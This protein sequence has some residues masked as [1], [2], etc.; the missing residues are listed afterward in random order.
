MS[1]SIETKRRLNDGLMGL[2]PSAI[3]EFFDL[4]THCDDIVSLGVGEPDFVTPWATREHAI[5]TLERGATTYTSNKGLPELRRGI[6]KYLHN[7]YGV[8]YD[9]E[10]EILV[11]VGVSQGLDLAM[12]SLLN[13][14]DEVIYFEPCYVAYQPMIVMAGG[15]P[16]KIDV[17]FEE[18]FRLDFQAI[19]D[20]VTDKTRAILVN[21][22]CNPTGAS[23]NREE[24]ERL[25]QVAERHDLVILSDEVYGELSYE[26]EHVSMAGLPG[27]KDKT[28][29]LNG[30]SKAFAMTGW[31]IGFAAGPEDIISAMTKL[32]QYAMLSAPIMSQ[33][34]AIEALDH[35]DIDVPPMVESYRQ[36]RR[37]IVHGLREAGLECHMPEGAFYAFPSIRETGLT[38]REF[39]TRLLQE[40][41]IAV[42][43]GNGFGDIGE[44]YLRCCYAV[45]VEEIETALGGIQS[46]MRRL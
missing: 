2:A 14:G 23:L 13:P 34:A 7:I 22:P 24:C 31:R 15:V 11:T 45:S 30:F 35:H 1:T 38:S 26:N 46:F 16:V 4:V 32:F 9:P 8:D 28:L 12:R 29:H 18:D 10:T 36:R 3:R 20:A 27:A 39:C 21:Y 42:V 44:G 41:R 19:E 5:F 37:L 33:H 25:V 43:P 6:A 40:E 17:K